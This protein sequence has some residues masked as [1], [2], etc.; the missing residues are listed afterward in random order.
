MITLHHC[1]QSR[2]MRVLWLLEELG[3]PYQVVEHP[4][5]RSLRSEPYLMLN[6]VGRVPSLAMDGE[7]IWESGAIIEVLCERFPERGLGRLPGEID[8]P[9]WLIWL[10]F[11]ETISQHVAA[12]T[13]QHIVL[14]E[15]AMR[16]PVVMRL[17]AKRLEKCY[18][19]IERRL[20]SPVENR[21]YLLTSGFSAV[22]IAVGQAVYMARHF[23]RTE[24]FPEVSAWYARITERPSFAAA[25][26]DAEHRLY[27]RD[28]YEPWE[29]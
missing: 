27:E 9:D 7:V 26:P 21:D 25:L 22:D 2:S 17:E 6:P 8:R 28:F 5:D 10:H 14:Y 29:G 18:G 1:P 24:A 23:A 13:Q 4:F 3:M 15:D 11:A 16:S 12:L 20:S 19:A